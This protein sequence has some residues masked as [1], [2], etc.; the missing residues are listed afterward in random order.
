M[1]NRDRIGGLIP[2]RGGG[3]VPKV[4]NFL[5]L[6][7][8]K[9][10]GKWLKCPIFGATGAKDYVNFWRFSETLPTFVK[11]ED[12]IA[13][14]SIVILKSF[15]NRLKPAL[16]DFSITEINS[17]GR[18]GSYMQIFDEGGGYIQTQS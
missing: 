1:S 8:P 7:A 13:W 11:V 6:K 18:E 10:W 12:F 15:L 14:K 16:K 3:F 2:E 17:E 4:S 9:N 5:A